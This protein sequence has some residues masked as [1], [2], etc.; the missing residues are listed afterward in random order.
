MAYAS[1]EPWLF[2]GS[3]RQNI[4]FGRKMDQLRYEQVVKVCQLKR[5]FRLLPNGDKTIVGERGISL[6]G[7]Q[8]ARYV[9][10]LN[11]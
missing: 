8:R 4:L 11:Y 2:V 3:V 10:F 5:D 1:Q 6:S 9:L 7:G